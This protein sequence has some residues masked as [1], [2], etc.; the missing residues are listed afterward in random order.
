MLSNEPEFTG[1]Y[2]LVLPKG[3]KPRSLRT[4]ELYTSGFIL[5][6]DPDSPYPGIPALSAWLHSAGWSSQRAEPEQERERKVETLHLRENVY[7]WRG[8]KNKNKT[9]LEFLNT[10]KDKTETEEV[11]SYTQRR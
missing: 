5:L 8:E 9:N 11:R 3:K 6:D 10:L 4:R 1:S 7:S 2:S